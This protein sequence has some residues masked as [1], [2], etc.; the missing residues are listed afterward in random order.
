M[1]NLLPQAQ[2]KEIRAG[3]SNALLLRYI[4][5]LICAF[6]FLLGSLGLSYYSLQQAAQTADT[7]KAENE[8]KATNYQTTQAA[9]AKLQSD[10][11]SAKSL[12]DNEVLYS[13]AIVR[14]ASLF[15]EGTAI[16]SIQFD[17]GSFAQQMTLSVQVKDQ[18]A[19]EAL[20]SSFNSSPYVSGANL[21]KIS[22]SGSGKYPYTVELLFT[23]N[24][25]IGQ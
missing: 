20:Q 8:K 16:D 10:L 23:L 24:K 11:S 18:A 3:Y 21:G 9:V 7:V 22:T 1:I 25:S 6:T 14:L 17:A 13:K 12:F 4:V 15:P 2:Q 19:A 5:L